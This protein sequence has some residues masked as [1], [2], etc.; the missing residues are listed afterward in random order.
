MYWRVAR[1]AWPMVLR[2]AAWMQWLNLVGTVVEINLF[3]ELN[4]LCANDATH[5]R[6]EYLG[7]LPDQGPNYTYSALA[8][9]VVWRLAMPTKQS[10][11]DTNQL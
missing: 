6:S 4:Q 2:Q 5:H 7:G 8:L 9:L 10:S 1:P 11:M 3:P